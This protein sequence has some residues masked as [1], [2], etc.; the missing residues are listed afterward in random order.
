MG[1][2]R[3]SS[4]FAAEKGETVKVLIQTHGGQDMAEV[5]LST[6]GEAARVVIILEILKKGLVDLMEKDMAIS[7]VKKRED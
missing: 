2:K 3:N 4:L 1:R 7:I 5:L 6:P